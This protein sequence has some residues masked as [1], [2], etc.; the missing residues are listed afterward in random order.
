MKKVLLIGGTGAMGVY[1]VPELLACGYAV[2]V[3]SLDDIKS[4][5]PNLRYFKGNARDKAFVQSVLDEGKYD[6]VVDFMIYN[7]HDFPDWYEMF[8][9]R[10]DHYIYLSSYRIY[11]DEEHPIKETSPRLLEATTDEDFRASNDYAIYKAQGEDTLRASSYRNWTIIRPAITYSSRRFQL[12]TLEMEKT[13]RRALL[14][15]T[16]VLPRGAKD[17]QATMTWAGDVAKMIAC[18]LFNEKAMRETY[19]VSTAE[20]HTWGEIADM[21]GELIGM[22]VMWV[23]AE[24]YIDT[25]GFGESALRENVWV[26]RQLKYDRLF[27]RIVDNSKILALMGKTQDDLMSLYDGLK[28]EIDKL[29]RNLF[30]PNSVESMDVWMRSKGYQE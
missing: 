21:Y 13:V 12:V 7:Q 26:W 28:L 1:L 27:D 6:G 20:H 10:T 22:K 14:G 30:N 18:I 3:L 24:D 5:T 2:D 17:K 4:D 15:R 25:F 23:S 19:T 11:A 29:P 8:L 9:D 16:V